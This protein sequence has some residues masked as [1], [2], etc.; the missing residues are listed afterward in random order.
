M[1]AGAARRER[2]PEV[3]GRGRPIGAF[4][5]QAT[6]KLEGPGGSAKGAAIQRTERWVGGEEEA[7]D[8]DGGG[9]VSGVG[10]GV[11]PEEVMLHWVSPE[12]I[13]RDK[14]LRD[15]GF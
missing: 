15:P 10:A 5:S 9:H 3:A 8:G 6:E 1:A 13:Q 12:M 11:E 7:R 2:H 4:G 14:Y